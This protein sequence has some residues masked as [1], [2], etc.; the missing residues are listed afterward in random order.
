MRLF[1]KFVNPLADLSNAYQT[2]KVICFILLIF[3]GVLTYSFFQLSR[4]EQIVVG[5][6]NNGMPVPMEVKQVGIE[7]LIN[8]KQFITYLLNCLYNWNNETYIE[9][10][11]RA[12]P[13][14]AEDIR[15]EYLSEVEEGGYID[16]IRQYKIIS[17]IQIKR[18]LE[19]T[20]RTYKDGFIIDV[21]AIKLRV[22]DFIDRTSTVRI[23]VAFRPTNFTPD[24]I[25][26]LEVFEIV[27]RRT[28]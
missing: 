5:I 7:N 4:R 25:W 20:A 6:D 24:N 11:R 14:L 16:T 9:Q 18:F 15:K 10:I 17:S 26:G 28:D 13:L 23:S 21:E 22:T 2:L 19:D 1:K 3:L 27:E 12:L 8:Y